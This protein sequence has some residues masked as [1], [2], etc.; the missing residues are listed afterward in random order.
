MIDSVRILST[1]YEVQEVPCID[2]E[3]YKL[4]H[5]DHVDQ[6][7]RID[8]ALRPDRRREVLLHEILHGLLWSLGAPEHGDERLI[9]GL[10]TG[11][12]QVFADNPELLCLFAGFRL[13]ESGSGQGL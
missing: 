10:S 7:I 13:G 6:V 12:S 5:I 11:L 3:D 1:T 8:Q 9:Q 4:G 2:R